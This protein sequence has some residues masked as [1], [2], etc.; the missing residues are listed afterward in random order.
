MKLRKS[1]ALLVL[2]AMCGQIFTQTEDGRDTTDSEQAA[3]K[4]TAEQEV[5]CI[6]LAK[7]GDK[8]LIVRFKGYSFERD[9]QGNYTGMA[10]ISSKEKTIGAVGKHT[11]YAVFP[12]KSLVSLMFS[13]QDKTVL[14][15][16][17]VL[18]SNICTVFQ[19]ALNKDLKDYLATRLT[20]I[21]PNV[22]IPVSRLN[23]LIKEYSEFPKDQRYIIESNLPGTVRYF[24]Q[25]ESIEHDPELIRMLKFLMKAHY[26]KYEQKN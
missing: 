4:A 3:L 9:E 22:A 10:T 15:Q 21:D 6:T 13:D 26:E 7:S 25:S 17:S 11:I 20:N 18:D 5:Y 2:L 16:K 19:V 12:K 8:P 24:K 14:Y 1:V 23:E